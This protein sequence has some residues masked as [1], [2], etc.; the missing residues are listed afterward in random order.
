[1]SSI[2]LVKFDRTF[3]DLSS[4]W[5]SDPHLQALIAAGPL[6]AEES[7]LK[8][9]ESLPDRKDYL[10]WGTLFEGEPIGACGLKNITDHDAEYWGYIGYKTLWGKGIGGG[11]IIAIQNIAKEI[12]IN[13][14]YLKVL[15][16]NTRAIK[17]YLKYGFKI[18]DEDSNWFYMS[19][20]I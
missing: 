14:L 6:P 16:F 12:G 20:L 9:F 8:W 1:M 19:L 15:K 10:I 13:S 18:D 17:M 4:Q 2:S 5:L 7:R 3:L 11:Y